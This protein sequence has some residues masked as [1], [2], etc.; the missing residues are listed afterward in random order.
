[1]LHGED[2]FL[3][4]DDLHDLRLLLEHV[5]KTKCVV[6]LQSK[7]VLTRPWVILELYT[8]IT[9]DV[10]IVPVKV[11][12]SFPYDFATALGFLRNFDNEI[13]AVNPGAASLLLS[14]GVDP[15][16]VAYRLSECLPNLIS[17]EFNPNAST[18]MLNVSPQSATA[19]TEV[20]LAHP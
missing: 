1:M 5:K 19:V 8:A 7:S 14:Y 10:P 16:D 12:N 2:V 9:N 20:Q 18:T 17:T 3:D 15:I 6:L 13:E 11:K 4:S